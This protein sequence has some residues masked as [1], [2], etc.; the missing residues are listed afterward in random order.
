MCAPPAVIIVHVWP[1]D[2]TIVR[3]TSARPQQ[4][5][6]FEVVTPHVYGRRPA[7]II[8]HA[9]P[10]GTVASPLLFN[11][12]HN[13]TFEVVTPHVCAWPAETIVQV[14]P[15]GTVVCAELLDPQQSSSL[16]GPLP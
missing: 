13:P 8:V 2:G 9:W 16:S 7:E 6:S 4:R 5:A 12:Q 1:P 15:G 14:W 3:P 10:D 11:P